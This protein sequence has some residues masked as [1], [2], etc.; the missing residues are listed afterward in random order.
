MRYLPTG[1][2]FQI[3]LFIENFPIKRRFNLGDSFKRNSLKPW[4]IVPNKILVTVPV[5]NGTVV[6]DF[7]T[8]NL[9]FFL[10]YKHKYNLHDFTIFFLNLFVSHLFI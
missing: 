6:R 1:A 8:K 10:F 4:I 3:F 9:S 7:L 2:F 5:R